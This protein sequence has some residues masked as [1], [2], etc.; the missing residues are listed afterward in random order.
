MEVQAEVIWD[1]DEAT[2]MLLAR[3]WV[4]AEATPVALLG[5]PATP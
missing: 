3:S 2:R 1:R 5:W 4:V